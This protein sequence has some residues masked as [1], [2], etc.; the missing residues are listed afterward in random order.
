VASSRDPQPATATALPSSTESAIHPD[1]R[2]NPNECI[3]CLTCQVNYY[4]AWVCRPM[5]ERRKR[6][7]KRAEILA[8]KAGAPDGGTAL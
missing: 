6:R 7:E 2:I 4:D 8:G 3:Y 1:G 5:I